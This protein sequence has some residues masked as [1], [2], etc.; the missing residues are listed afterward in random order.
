MG[1]YEN[2]I[3]PV[4]ENRGNVTMSYGGCV[5]RLREGARQ[6]CTAN[7]ERRFSQANACQLQLTLQMAYTIPDSVVV[8]HG[9]VGCGSQSNMMEFGTRSAS[10][11]R[12]IKRERL[13]WVSS[14]LKNEDVIA[15]GADK[16]I[17]AVIGADRTY[18]PKIIFV[19][20]TCTPSIIGD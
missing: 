6:G 4:R 15:G 18:A 8:V 11:V 12:G 2:K 9:P 20:T 17:D 13:I 7:C 3:P 10:A 5:G 19:A 14:N 1:Y 16:L